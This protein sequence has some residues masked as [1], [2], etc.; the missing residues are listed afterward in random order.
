MT[1]SRVVK[2]GPKGQVVIPKII[3]D[4]IGLRPGERVEVSRQGSEVRVRR[5]LMLDELRGVFAPSPGGGTGEL[6]AEH[7]AELRQEDLGP[8]D[9]RA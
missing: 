7:L 6:E 1:E 3:R 8:P 4:L 5:S 9:R 2:V